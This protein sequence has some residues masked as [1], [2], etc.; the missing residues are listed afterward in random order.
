[1]PF[2][3]EHAARQND[4]KKYKRFRRQ[5]NKFGVGIHAIFGITQDNKAE[6][7]SI[8]FD[9]SKFSE[10]QA[11]KWLKNHKYKTG[12]EVAT[13]KSE[14]LSEWCVVTDDVLTEVDVCKVDM[15]NRCIFGWAS[16]IEKEGESVIDSQGD[17]IEEEELEKAV[18]EYMLESREAGDNHTVTEGV[19]KIIE[20]IVF[21]KEKQEM[22]N[23]DLGK[24]GWFVG[25]AIDNEETLSKI[26]DNLYLSFSIGGSATREAIE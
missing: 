21:T 26:K 3:N 16:V 24:V 9:S 14:E 8:R 2:P 17:I 19:G 10:E 6:V 20:S 11:R 4:P 1:M 18:Y 22:L 7:Q 23:I 13:K 5:N 15:E 25:F 12:L